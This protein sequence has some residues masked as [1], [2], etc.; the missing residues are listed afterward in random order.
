[1]ETL[2]QIPIVGLGEKG[3]STEAY[4]PDKS[5]QRP[6]AYFH[7]VLWGCTL[8]QSRVFNGEC[9]ARTS[10]LWIIRLRASHSL[11]ASG[12][13]NCFWIFICSFFSW[14]IAP[15]V[16]LWFFVSVKECYLN[17]FT[18]IHN[19]SL[20]IDCTSVTNV[21]W[22]MLCPLIGFHED[23]TWYDSSIKNRRR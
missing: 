22:H 7:W 1:M 4:G 17:V 14:N 16:S 13:E 18:V 8:P 19:S 11:W 20:I 10:P 9:Q 3:H 5:S 2:N 15:T 12:A 21:L 6:P 23:G